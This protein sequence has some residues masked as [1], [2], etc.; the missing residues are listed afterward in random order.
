M[1]AAPLTTIKGGIN[2]LRLKGGARA[3]SLY[4]LLNAYCTQS[5]TVVVR[6]GTLRLAKLDS[7]TRGLTAFDGSLHTFCHQA[8]YVPAGFT[9]NLLVHPN[10]TTETA[11]ATFVLTAAKLELT[12]VYDV[13]VGADPGDSLGNGAFGSF[14]PVTL[15]NGLTLVSFYT[16]GDDPLT[17]VIGIRLARD[18]VAAPTDA[19][20]SF[21]FTDS[22]LF[23]RT[24]ATVDADVPDGVDGGTYREWTWTLPDAPAQVFVDGFKYNVTFDATT[25]TV[26]TVLGNTIALNKIHFAEPFMGALYVVAEFEN[27]NIYHYWLQ[28]GKQWEAGHIYKAGDLVYPSTPTGL[29]YRASRLGSANPPWA[30]NVPR[31]DGTGGSGYEQSI[32]EPTVY[33]DYFYTCIATTGSNPRSGTEEPVWPTE[34]GATVIE[35]TDN[36][37]DVNTPTTTQ[38][39]TGSTAPTS[40]TTDRYGTFSDTTREVLR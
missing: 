14:E 12:P 7:A 38:D 26:T 30:A 6:P 37:P 11:A 5:G 18:G 28:P 21:T 34:D 13:Y 8:V 36:P 33:N 10:I 22:L 40:G 16:H 4:D 9:L 29:V 24:F 15:S 25:G 31:Y 23:E 1:R 17:S 2:R 35:S 20:E 27:G 3:D 19:F 32:I 39:P